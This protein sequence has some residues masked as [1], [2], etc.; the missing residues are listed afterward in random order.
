MKNQW[1]QNILESIAERGRELL[2]LDS[3]GTNKQNIYALCQQLLGGQGE[4][5]GVALSQEILRIYST[6][7]QPTSATRRAVCRVGHLARQVAQSQQVR[8]IEWPQLS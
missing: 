6:H 7:I 5:S 4:A 2:G 3:D 8:R 1:L